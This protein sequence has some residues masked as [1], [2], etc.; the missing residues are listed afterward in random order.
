MRATISATTLALTLAFASAANA[1]FRNIELR[2]LGM[3]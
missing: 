2:T 1:E 3:D